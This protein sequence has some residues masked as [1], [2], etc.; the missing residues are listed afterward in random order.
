MNTEVA[1]KSQETSS[2]P[3]TGKA[4][5]QFVALAKIG[6]PYGLT[7]AMHVFPYSRDA[8]TLR[9]AKQV[10]IRGRTYAVSSLR[11]HGDA[12]VMLLDGVSSP[13]LAAT[14]TNADI[15]VSRDL[16]PALPSGEFYWVDLVGLECVNVA[17]NERV[18]G[19]V[20]EV[21]EV[22]AHPILRVRSSPDAN[23]RDD[24]LIPFVDAIIRSVDMT[25]RR[26]DVDWHGLHGDDEPRPAPKPNAKRRTRGGGGAQATA[27]EP[28]A[29]SDE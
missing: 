17:A 4:D 26:I 10:L 9:R 21:F 19:V 28:P 14:F 16:F 15:D 2:L 20:V 23:E 12:Y 29:L 22:G 7:G 11:A 24:E 1:L 8:A 3:S 27:A 18:F 6:R 25:A 5:A 13:E